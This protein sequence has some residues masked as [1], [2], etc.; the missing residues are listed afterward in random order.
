LDEASLAL[1]RNAGINEF[2]HFATKS[3]CAD[4]E[5]MR[6]QNLHG[7]RC[8]LELARIIGAKR[9]VFFSTAFT[10]GRQ[11]GPV[12]EQLHSLPREFHNS[13][14]ES[15]CQA[16]HEV[17]SFCRAQKMDYR[18]LRPSIVIGPSL[19]MKTGGCRLGLYGLINELYDLH[20]N[21]LNHSPSSIRNPNSLLNL[22]PVD[23]LMADVNNLIDNNFPGGPIYHLTSTNNLTAGTVFRMLCEIM[24]IPHALGSPAV[25]AERSSFEA[26][27]DKG[28]SFSSVSM[29]DGKEFERSLEREDGV[30]RDELYGYV[31]ECLREL[32]CETEVDLLS[33]SWM[34]TSDGPLVC[35]YVGGSPANSAVVLIN[36]I[37]MAVIF[38]LPLVR[39]LAPRFRIVT[40]E[41]RWAPSPE[42]VFDP[43]RCDLDH[44]LR[45]LLSLLDSN[46]VDRAHIVG[47]CS[48]AQIA[49]KFAAFFPER[50]RSLVLL[51]GAFN[52]PGN[53]SRTVFEKNLRQLM[54]KIARNAAYAELYSR[55][56]SE[57][58]FKLADRGVG[59]GKDG[60]QSS[61]WIPCRN[62]ELRHLTN[63]PFKTP[64]LLYRYA[65]MVTRT[66]E[67]SEHAWT[68]N[69]AVPVLVVSSSNDQI[70]RPETS[71]DISE[72]I[73]GATHVMIEDGDH[74]GLH[75]D[76]RVQHT[77]FD[78][79]MSLENGEHPR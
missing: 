35:S 67:E 56:I 79:L 25:G 16:E 10:V 76:E 1:V 57:S 48:G 73:K 34:Q 60:G 52:L 7:T 5:T 23:H 18:I 72:Q 9:F 66:F 29:L 71:R 6:K 3:N 45:D 75:D 55:I 24:E 44:H 65:N 51:N 11:L 53:T 59:Q 58:R 49:L 8:A 70:T 15:L 26:S 21:T 39:L 68:G 50:T 27:L 54:P 32:R 62:P 12:P 61:G 30:T 41:S 46:G 69:I 33:R 64:E 37:G 20:A 17:A 31:V 63:G 78:F 74:H 38:W 77:V 42:G 47:W 2:W 43:Q 22:I 28:I 13:Y 4:A 19:T 14:E 36:A 40:W